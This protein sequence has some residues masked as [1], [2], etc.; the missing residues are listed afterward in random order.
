MPTVIVSGR[1]DEVVRSRANT[2]IRAQGL[3]TGDVIKA[4]WSHIAHTGEVP[5]MS[6]EAEASQDAWEAFMAFRKTLPNPTPNTSGIAHMTPS[7][8]KEFIAEER[9][10][11]YEKLQ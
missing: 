1:V 6:E 9:L 10:K 5:R 4:V 11:D 7:E 3:T 8:L 2:Y